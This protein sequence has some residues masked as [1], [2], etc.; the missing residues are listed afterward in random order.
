MAKMTVI[1]K[2]CIVC[3]QAGEVE[4]EITEYDAW[5]S[6]QF[7]QHALKSN[8][9]NEREQL[10]SGTHPKCWDDIFGKEE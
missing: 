5:V 2:P 7:A 9:A 3:G 8:N 4:V 10:I 1:T 6:G